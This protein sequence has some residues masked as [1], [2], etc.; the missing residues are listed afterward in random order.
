MATPNDFDMRDWTEQSGTP[1][2]D[3]NFPFSL[4]PSGGLNTPFEVP[5]EASRTTGVA[6][7]SVFF[8]AGFSSG[9]ETNRDFHDLY[10]AWAF[11]DTGAGTWSV[12]GKSKNVD[13]GG[14]ASHL[15]ETPGTYDVTLLV[16]DGIDGSLL[17]SD[18]F[19]ITVTD[20]DTVFAGTL[21]VC[22]SDTTNDDFT[23]APAGSTHVT[24]D[25][26]SDLVAHTGT[27]KRILLHRGSTW[28]QPGILNI[29]SGGLLQIGAYGTGTNPDAKGI[30][31]NAPVIN[32]T[33]NDGLFNMDDAFDLRISDLEI[34]GTSSTR[35]IVEGAINMRRMLI[36]RVKTTH[37]LGGVEIAHWRDDANDAIEE[38][39]FIE[40]DI[41]GTEVNGLHVG[42]K[43]LTVMGNVVADA[44]DGHIIRA[45]WSYLGT[46][47]HNDISGSAYISGNGLHALKFHGSPD[48]KIGTFAE[49]GNSGLPHKSKFTMVANN[50]AG[51]SGPWPLSL[52]PQNA[53][54]NENISDIIVEKN[55]VINDHGT[56][57][58]FAVQ[59]S[60]ILDGRYNTARN[61]VWD[62]TGASAFYTGLSISRRG[63]EDTPKGTHAYNNT[64]Y[65]SDAAS[66]A[67]GIS[68]HSTA[69]DTIAKN[70]LVSFENASVTVTVDDNSSVAT[71]SNNDSIDDPLF[72][73][74]DNASPELRDFDITAGSAAID[75]GTAV[76]V[77]D[78][79]E[80][81]LRT[82][83]NDTG[84]FNF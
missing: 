46:I 18:T 71:L 72:A 59:V 25:T 57:T 82:G 28:S 35:G 54:E 68:I 39:S 2:W 75:A 60:C 24:T 26:I 5:R 7:L 21:T 34:P 27:G 76:P 49:T 32:L 65:T 42:C 22:F 64:T 43:H 8:T 48:H 15:F 10:Y 9:S 37:H 51:S 80:D 16:Y 12:S 84:A 83:T 61:N 19:E 73:D 3:G 62:G 13:F 33:G 41:S 53:Q 78:D 55:R 44:R 29:A 67:T 17:D 14:S 30:F 81:T 77:N 58:P 74:P 52:G 79:L 38:L 1:K 47:S 40:N 45:W 36:L 63:V 50:L 69:T 31:D 56:A 11:D 23:G 4:R 6:P 70:N 66:E 20:P